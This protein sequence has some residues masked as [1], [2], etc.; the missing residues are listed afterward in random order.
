MAAKIVTPKGQ[1]WSILEGTGVQFNVN[2]VDVFRK[3]SAF[4]ENWMVIDMSIHMWPCH[5]SAMADVEKTDEERVYL[6][7]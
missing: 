6:K 5:T 7:V 2:D 1:I 4:F 3:I